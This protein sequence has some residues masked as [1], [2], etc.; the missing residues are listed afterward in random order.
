M[1]SQIM[2]ETGAILHGPTS[3]LLH[4]NYHRVPEKIVCTIRLVFYAVIP[5]K[6]VMDALLLSN[7]DRI[8]ITVIIVSAHRPHYALG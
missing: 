2:V 8:I 6:N 5:S 1:Y 3:T 7:K 4:N